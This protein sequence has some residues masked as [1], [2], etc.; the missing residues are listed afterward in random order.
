M[1]TVYEHLHA[2]CKEKNLPPPSKQDIESCGR[3]I[4][5]HFKNFWGKS[6]DTGVLVGFGFT[7]AE[8]QGKKYVIMIYPDVFKPEMDARIDIYYQTKNKP[9]PA[10][11]I[12][13]APEPLPQ[14]DPPKKR[15]RIAV[16]GPVKAYSTKP[17]PLGQ[18][19]GHSQ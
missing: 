9:I 1:T 3:M 2:Y 8:E 6:Q 16:A 10:P 15:K 12:Q 11:Q 13:S 19:Q 14:K 17:S 4:C 7:V 5:H 18:I